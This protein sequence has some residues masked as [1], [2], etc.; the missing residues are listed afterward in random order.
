LI[1]HLMSRRGLGLGTEFRFLSAH[2]RGELDGNILPYDAA[3]ENGATR[4]YFDLRTRADWTTL[5]EG[6]VNFNYVS[7]SKYFEDFGNSLAETSA[8]QVERVGALRYY[9]D[10]WDLLGRLQYYQ[11]LDRDIATEDLPYSRLPQV[12]FNYDRP[13]LIASL[14]GQMRAEY[15]N[16]W[17]K[18]T[19]T[20]Q[21]VDLKP[22]LSLP[23]RRP[24]GYLEPSLQGRYTAYRLENA[25]REALSDDTPDR[26]LGIASL[27]A[28]LYFERRAHWFGGPSRQTLEPRLFYLY[29]PSV[30][31]DDLPVFDTTEVDLSFDS[32]FRENRFTGADR[33]GDANQVALALISRV[34]DDRSGAERL[35]AALGQVYFFSD[36]TVT[37]PGEPETSDDRSAVSAEV[38]AQF[39]QAWKA[40]AGIIWD[41]NDDR[42]DQALA[43]VSYLDADRRAYN[44]GYRF[45]DQVVDETNLAFLWP[46]SDQ[47]RLIGRWNY[48]L[49]NDRTLEAVAGVEYGRCCWRIRALLRQFTNGPGDDYNLAFW[50]QLEL[51]GLGQVGT[52]VDEFLERG[53]YGYRT[54]DY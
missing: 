26:L 48:S 1:P 13:A 2:Y 5:F 23:L 20:G 34:L 29:V 25:E 47:T 33:Q 8:R 12:L 54:D 30:N 52:D 46:V 36:R 37:L 16:F 11:N 50:L 45:R 21:R 22:G 51:N 10:T 4:G 32:L 7:D 27:D 39:T 28:G 6:R 40:R 49:L 43:Q 31:Q 15:A 41:P 53:V 17:R 35:R 19:L 38:A 3:F 24:W 14:S 44:A 18:D 9:E 42:V